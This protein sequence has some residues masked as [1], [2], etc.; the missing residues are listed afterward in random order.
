M[1]L[2]RLGSD[3]G[4]CGAR[5]NSRNALHDTP[6]V[7]TLAARK[8]TETSATVERRPVQTQRSASKEKKEQT[9]RL[10]A[11]SEKHHVSPSPTLTTRNPSLGWGD[12][13][14][15]PP[16]YLFPTLDTGCPT[17]PPPSSVKHS[18]KA[19]I[20]FTSSSTQQQQHVQWQGRRPGVTPK[21]RNSCP[22]SSCFGGC[23]GAAS[24]CSPQTALPESGTGRRPHSLPRPR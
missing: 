20:I 15:L 10:A 7:A 12:A 8:V 18:F 19:R 21:S 3:R 23:E 14:T 1:R 4:G 24:P 6:A 16:L 13:L 9:L 2:F 11:H 22:R 5:R 17:V